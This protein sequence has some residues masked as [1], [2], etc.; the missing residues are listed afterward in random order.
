VTLKL[1][2]HPL[3]PYARKVK[4]VLYEKGIP[5]ERVRV[6]PLTIRE[7]DPE[8]GEF[9]ASSPRLEVPCLVDGEF[10]CFDSTIIADYLD[11]KWPETPM[12]SGSPEERARARMVEE[13]SDS[14]LEAINWGMME[15]RF[16]KRAEGAEAERMVESARGQLERVWDRL[17]LEFDRSA[18]LSGAKFGRADA[19][20]IIHVV[21]AGLFGMPPLE[22]HAR[23]REWTGRCLGVEGVKR[24]QADLAAWMASDELRGMRKGP[25]RRQYRDHRLE[26]MLKSGGIEVVLRGMDKNSI[27]FSAFP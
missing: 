9:A 25:I 17:E 13:L 5:F 6:T 15:I 18:W 7:E 1:F 26:W 10:R 22:R 8:Y 16:F 24:D 19:S 3:S 4:I 23:L 12:L 27:R 20:V 21:N 14:V 2:E 11:E